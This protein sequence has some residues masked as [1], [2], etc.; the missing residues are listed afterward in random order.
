ME[1]VPNCD[2][3][4]RLERVRRRKPQAFQ[5]SRRK[6]LRC[7]LCGEYFSSQPALKEHRRGP[8]EGGRG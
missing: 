4:D 3:P 7:P 2:D 6:K 1:I 5:P 8:F